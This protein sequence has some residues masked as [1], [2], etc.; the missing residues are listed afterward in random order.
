MD[1][2]RQWSEIKDF[3]K[4][5]PYA[6]KCSPYCR[7]SQ[8]RRRLPAWFTTLKGWMIIGFLSVCAYYIPFFWIPYAV[9]MLW[10]SVITAAS[11]YVNHPRNPNSLVAK[12]FAVQ[13]KDGS[14][15]TVTMHVPRYVAMG[16]YGHEKN[17]YYY[18]PKDFLT[19]N[20]IETVSRN[21]QT[22]YLHNC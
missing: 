20:R 4:T 13:Y 11:L 3:F 5:I 21:F 2:K 19:N 8:T 15:R 9:L 1:V 12:D 7:W 18:F 22:H 14:E 17:Q 16:Y 6:S 10:I